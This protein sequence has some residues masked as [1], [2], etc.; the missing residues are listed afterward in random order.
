MLIDLLPQK[1][2]DLLFV[3][4]AVMIKQSNGFIGSRYP[5]GDEGKETK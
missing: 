4:F 3:G 2:G 1:R 5:K